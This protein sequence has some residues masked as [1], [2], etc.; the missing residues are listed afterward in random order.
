[1]L[2]KALPAIVPAVLRGKVSIKTALLGHKLDSKD[3]DQVKRLYAKVEGRSERVELNLYV[4]GEDTT[5]ESPPAEGGG[6]AAP[7]TGGPSDP[8]KSGSAA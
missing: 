3:L 5:P 8:E 4:V 2:L 7:Q 6:T 1:M